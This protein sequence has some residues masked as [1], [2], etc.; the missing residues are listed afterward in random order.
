MSVPKAVVRAIVKRGGFK[1]T[2]N[3]LS[4]R[5]H[6][7]E[8]Q[9]VVYSTQESKTDERNN[10]ITKYGGSRVSNDVKSRSPFE[11]G[12]LKS[13]RTGFFTFNGKLCCEQKFHMRTMRKT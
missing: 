11:G 2:A 1:R 12:R 4:A 13:G 6:L 9:R 7:L 5:S 3:E 8:S 10:L